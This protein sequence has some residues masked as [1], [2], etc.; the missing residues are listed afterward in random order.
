MA[1]L[2]TRT[3]GT[4]VVDSS[5][6]TERAL[7][8]QY[9]E[10]LILQV[11]CDGYDPLLSRLHQKEFIWFVPNDDNRC[12]DALDLRTEFIHERGE[13]AGTSLIKRL[14]HISVLEVLVGISRR[15]EFQMGGD[16]RVWAMVLVANLE[17]SKFKGRLSHSDGEEIDEIVQTLVW[18]RYQP[19][20]VGG[21]FP[22]AWPEEDQ[23]KV[24]IWNQM[25]AWINEQHQ[26]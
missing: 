24:E 25:S 8:H 11:D 26:M 12:Q 6:T 1:S 21:F 2:S 7:K 3:S 9:L 17:L 5:M 10:W 18:R 13:T 23:S 14:S 4:A 22:L 20:G 15:M 16:A 19:D